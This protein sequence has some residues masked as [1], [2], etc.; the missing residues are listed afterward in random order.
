MKSTSH[1]SKTIPLGPVLLV[2]FIGAMGFS[3]VLPFLIFLVNRMGGNALVYGLVG[4]T[5]PVFQFIGAPILGR[6]SDRYGR[7]KILL[8]SQ[9]GTL[10][11]WLIFSVALFLPMTELMEVDSPLLGKFTL[12]LPLLIVFFARALDGLTGGNVSVANAY[13]ADV[14]TEEDRNR[15]FGRMG[16]A[17]NLG[18][19]LGPALASLLGTTALG[20]KLPVFAAAVISLAATIVIAM[21]LPES[22]PCVEPIGNGRGKA[23][24]V[25]GQEHRD[26]L[27]TANTAS[28]KTSQLL[29]LPNVLFML[30]LYFIILL[31]F[32]FFYTAF[33]VHAALNLKWTVVETGIFFSVLSFLLVLV[34]GPVLSRLSKKVKEPVLVIVGC[35]ILGTNFVFMQSSQVPLLYVA[36]VLFAVGNGIMWPSVLSLLSKVADNKFQGAIQGLAGS[37]GSLASVFGLVV[38]GILF[39]FIGAATM[40]VSAVLAYISFILAFRLLR[41]EKVKEIT[42]D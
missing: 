2:N 26:C 18:L 13:V 37:A 17:S 5:Y 38:G 40:M 42:G 36:V 19:I 7:R 31:S 29:K 4:A 30:V 15:N 6:W 33:P 28:Q 12:T 21:I 34:E 25:F 9:A 16:V 20:E 10:L 14:S 23:G 3:I 11:S 8:L 27:K 1:H 24:K 41:Q 39:G 22:K 35:V 32:N